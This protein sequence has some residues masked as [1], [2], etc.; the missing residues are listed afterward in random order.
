MLNKLFYTLLSFPALVLNISFGNIPFRYL[1]NFLIV[2]YL[3]LKK[4]NKNS[5]YFLILIFIHILYV[6][7]TELFTNR[8]FH[9]IDISYILN[10]V[11][12]FI[13]INLVYKRTELFVKFMYYFTIVNII[14]A[15][16]QNLLIL[17]GITNINILMLFSNIKSD[18]Y[19]IPPSP[20]IG[21]FGFYRYSGLFHES[22]PF[23]IF[24]IFSH[25]FFSFI[26]FKKY[27]KNIL[28][29]VIVF[30]GAKLG[31]LYLILIFLVKV[32]SFIKIRIIY[33]FLMI[34]FLA[35]IFLDFLKSF[36][37]NYV[38]GTSIGTLYLRF[39]D[40]F[41]SINE[42]TSSWINILFGLGFLPSSSTMGANRGLDFFSVF[43]LSNGLIGTIILIFPYLL[44]IHKA[45][46][47]LTVKEQNILIIGLILSLLS[48]GSLLIIQY[49]YLI[50]ILI[51]TIQLRKKYD[52]YNST[53]IC[54][55]HRN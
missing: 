40:M 41:D 11:F 49:T 14:W 4:I 22:V 21:Q 47:Y 42:F 26:V 3:N 34:S 45:S 53:N 8:K 15:I 23:V 13:S 5:F 17:F 43:I 19:F 36:L 37:L 46:K 29:L 24:L 6:F 9:L 32:F 38:N 7:S 27:L 52:V 55:S 51:T 54:K 48:S 1:G 31:L 39:S 20:Y 16:I 25:F 50:L 33:I 35:I 10:Y 18:L 30:S 28:L 12:I 2:K 44:I